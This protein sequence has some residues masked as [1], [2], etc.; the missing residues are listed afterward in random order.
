MR[1]RN[2]IGKSGAI[3]AGAISSGTPRTARSSEINYHY[4]E[5]ANLPDVPLEPGKRLPFGWSAFAVPQAEATN[6]PVLKWSHLPTDRTARL[7]FTTA[8]DLREEIRID[9]RLAESGKTIGKLD[10][11]FAPVLEPFE[12]LLNAQ[13]IQEVAGQGISL[14]MTK[15]KS[16]VWFFQVDADQTSHGPLQAHLLFSDQPDSL[17][18]FYHRMASPVSLQPWGWMEGCVMD[19]L[20]DLH[21]STGESR[22]NRTLHNHISRFF[23][24]QNQLVYED[25]KSR[26][27]DGKVSDIE[28]TLPHAVLARI[29][30][31][32]PIFEKV[33]AFWMNHRDEAGCVRDGSTTS[34]EGSYTIAYPMMV[35]GTQRND[36]ALINLAIQQL[37]LRRERLISEGDCWLRYHSKGPSRSFQNWARGCAWYSLGLVRTLS[38]YKGDEDVSDLESE[39]TRFAEW[40]RGYQKDSGLWNCFF[41]KD[42]PPDTS[43]SAGVAAALAIA[44]KNDILPDE[45]LEVSKLTLKGLEKYLTPDGFL[46]GVAQSNRGGQAL[47]ESDYRVIS[48]MGMGLMAQLAAAVS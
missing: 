35:I 45:Y 1:R 43:G 41:H 2:F 18:E 12:L 4:P 9:V 29:T 46:T 15:G 7:R 8:V 20:Y 42:V 14:V 33:I 25:P 24:E 13:Q 17:S 19:G 27:N 6:P 31:D 10:I 21:Q 22:F 23:D 39:V 28:S 16:P 37:R 48:Q 30:P 38:E 36:E 3:L 11:R 32:H 40:A 47:Q 44:V 5:I 26:P 34:A